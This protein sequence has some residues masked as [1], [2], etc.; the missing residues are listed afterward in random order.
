MVLLLTGEGLGDPI[1]VCN[2]EHRFAIMEQLEEIGRSARAIILEPEGRGTAPA[3]AAA[4]AYLDAPTDDVLVVPCDLEIGKRDRFLASIEKGARAAAEGRI[5]VFGVVPTRPESGF[6]YVERGQELAGLEGVF[7]LRAFHEKP[8]QARA[9]AFAGSGKHYWNGGIFLGS[10][11]T[12]IQELRLHAPGIHELALRSVAGGQLDLGF[13]RLDEASFKAMPTIGFDH[14]VMER[15]R[16]GAVVPLDCEWNDLGSWAAIADTEDADSSGNA[17]RGAAVLIESRGNYVRSDKPLVA[18]VGVSN[19]VVVATDDAVL[20]ADRGRTQEVKRVVS[21]LARAERPEHILHTTVYRP[22]GNYQ[23]L[24]SGARFKVK[25]I[26]VKPHSKLSLQRHRHRSEHWVVVKGR[27]TVTQG[28]ST[29]VLLENESTYIPAGT[30]HRLAN[31]EDD[32][33]EVVE[34]QTGELLDEG[35]I[36]RLSDSFGRADGSDC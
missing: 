32:P 33:L 23:D 28:E 21:E 29:I 18:L 2:H 19:L 25:R 6:G 15:T 11:N 30:V 20:V 22:W 16:A 27:A 14:A 8:E 9:E 13:F 1:V 31:E 3:I 4:L 17:H 35:D 12:L 24:D 36:E 10:A 26:T 5:A 34:V 7:A